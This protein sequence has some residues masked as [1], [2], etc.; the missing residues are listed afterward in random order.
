MAK[1]Y[2][3]SQPV[4]SNDTEEGR[5]K[6][7]RVEL[8]KKE[9][10]E[11]GQTGIRLSESKQS[12][13]VSDNDFNRLINS[14]QKSN[15]VGD[16]IEAVEYLKKAILSI[17]DDVPLTARNIRLVSDLKNYTSKK[18]NVYRKGE[19]ICLTSQIFGHRLKK[20]GDSYEIN[21]T[22]DFLVLDETGTVSYT[23]LTLPTN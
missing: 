5:A 9:S 15:N 17:W 14:A 16:R 22:T 23:H 3:L 13:I 19:T 7:R 1:G 10:I 12:P 4:A 20:H 11:T 2:G 6:N 21:I 8:V 18:N